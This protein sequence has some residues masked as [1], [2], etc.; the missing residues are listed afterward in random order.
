VA[1]EVGERMARL[2]TS[3]ADLRDDVKDNRQRIEQVSDKALSAS[4]WT[5]E[6]RRLDERAAGH[7]SRIVALEKARADDQEAERV[8][9]EKAADQRRSDKRLIV[10]LAVTAFVG[11]LLILL[12]TVLINLRGIGG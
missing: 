12:V 3:T 5:L 1:D 10:T 9:R 2:E 6:N 8:R 11:P 4:Q 7:L